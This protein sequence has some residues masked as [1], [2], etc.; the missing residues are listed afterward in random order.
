MKPTEEI[1]FELQKAYDFFNL[2]FFDGKLPFCLITLQRKKNTEGYF[3]S[4]RFTSLQGLR[5]DE[6][7]MNPIYFG[8]RSIKQILSTIAHEMVH[9]WQQHFGTPSRGGY[10]NK[11][12]ANKMESIGLMPSST[13]SPGGKR[14]GQ[15]MSDYIIEGGVFDTLCDLLITNEYKISWADRFI[16]PSIQDE[17]QLQLTDTENELVSDFNQDDL[18]ELLKSKKTKYKYSCEDCKVSVWGKGGLSLKCGIH[19]TYMIPDSDAFDI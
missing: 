16:S 1:Y 14:T 4:Q 7:A 15:K 13:G 9:Q 6:I 18:E 12:W 3:C 10:H 8:I 11:E 2:N 19:D 17:M 5:T